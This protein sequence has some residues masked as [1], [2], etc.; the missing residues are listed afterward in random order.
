MTYRPKPTPWVWDS[1]TDTADTTIGSDGYSNVTIADHAY[2]VIFTLKTASG[3]LILSTTKN[4][5]E[6]GDQT[7]KGVVLEDGAGGIRN[8]GTHVEPGT[9]IRV[10]GAQNDVFHVTTFYNKL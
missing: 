7:G 10:T 5:G 1:N 9:V 3:D 8:Y 4:E 6:A 2:Y